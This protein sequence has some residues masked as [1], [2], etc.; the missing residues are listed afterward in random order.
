MPAASGLRRPGGDDW[1]HVR[2]RPDRR[3]RDTQRP[4]VFHALLH[5]QTYHRSGSRLVVA[6]RGSESNLGWSGWTMIRGRFPATSAS[7]IRAERTEA[8]QMPSM[9]AP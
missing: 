4:E 7:L 2:S 6:A 5:C 9:F 1:R 3:Y 8:M